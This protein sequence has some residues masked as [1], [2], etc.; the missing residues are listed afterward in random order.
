[1][2][3]YG[4]VWY[5]MVWYGMVWYGMEWYGMVWYG[6]EWYGMVWYGMVW[7]LNTL[8]KE[9][10]IL[11]LNGCIPIPHSLFHPALQFP[12]GVGSVQWKKWQLFQ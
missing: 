12:S 7:Y 4:M 2:V 10:L 9:N 1:M 5:G 6:M 3:W 11:L 8:N